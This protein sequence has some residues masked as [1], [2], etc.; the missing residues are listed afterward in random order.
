MTTKQLSLCSV[1]LAC[2]MILGCS[3]A[4][5]PSTDLTV[6][7]RLLHTNDL[8]G[9]MLGYDYFQQQENRSLGLAH[10]AT[11]VHQA[12]LEQPNHLLLDNGDTIQGSAMAD[13]AY[14]QGLDYLA[15]QRHPV[16]RAMNYLGYHAAA[17]GNHEFNYGLEFLD[18]TIEGATFPVLSA[19]IFAADT[20]DS[21]WESTRFTPYVIQEHSFVGSDMQRHDI[22]VGLLG[23][24]PPD[25]MRWD[26]DH[27]KGQV[28]VRDMVA[29]ARHFVP[30]MKAEGAD[31]VILI[32]HTGLRHYEEYPEG[33]EQAALYLAQVDG[34]DAL[35]LGHQHRQLPGDDYQGMP[36]VDADKG[37]IHGVPAVMGGQYGSHLGLIDLTLQRADD[38]WVVVNQH[39]EL[40]QVGDQRDELLVALLVEEQ[41]QTLAMLNQPLGAIDGDIDNFFARVQPNTAIQ[42][43]NDAQHWYASKLQEAGELPADLPIVSAAAPFRSGF[44]GPEDYTH[45]SAGSVTLGNIADLYIYPNTL[46]VIELDGEQ[47]RDWL[48]MSAR[49]F[50]TIDPNLED[51]QELLQARIPSY[52]FDMMNQVSYRIDVTQPARFDGE[53]K[54]IN[55]SHRIV[56]LQYQGEPVTAEQRFLVTINNYRASGGGFFPHATTAPVHYSG[57]MEV[58]QIIAEYTRQQA[59]EH[60]EQIPVELEKNWQLDIPAGT[61]VRFRSSGLAAAKD[62]AASLPQLTLLDQDEEGYG[63]YQLLPE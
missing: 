1:V 42:W 41:A 45:L 19:N 20:A 25:I 17:L 46:R 58:R 26:R 39:A 8:H 22:R 59:S 28:Q 18:A 2:S 23:L 34:V 51:W 16:I 52:N 57:Q 36:G 12:R 24:V 37:L 7:V 55:D 13:W 44:G 49:T 6:E 32:A 62:A 29:T 63:I 48:E 31:V 61:Q 10:V 15:E 21:D 27:L 53:G 47:L 14:A 43:V 50:A 3:P 60:G 38:G 30:H 40:R 4:E 56:D 35:L 33:A 9:Y 5:R 11:L 54:K